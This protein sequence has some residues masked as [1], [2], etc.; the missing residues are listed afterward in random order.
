MKSGITSAMA[1]F[2]A[3]GAITMSCE[4]EQLKPAKERKVKTT[5]EQT[6]DGGDDDDDPVI[7]GKVKKSNGL[8]VNNASVETL[9][10]GTNVSIGTTYT[11]TTGDYSQKVSAGIYYLKVT[12]PSSGIPVYTDTVH[13]NHD[14]TV[15]V[16]AD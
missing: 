7:R 4:K 8:A 9:T 2:V 16:T 12:N 15:N 13:V 14:V 1:I 6:K 5:T 11:N 10:Y 3:L